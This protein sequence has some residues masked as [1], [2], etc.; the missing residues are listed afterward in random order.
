MSKVFKQNDHVILKP[1]EEEPQQE[2]IIVEKGKSTYIIQLDARFITEFGDDG[3]REVTQDQ[4][5]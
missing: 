4:I 1:F 2:G 3:Y 5:K